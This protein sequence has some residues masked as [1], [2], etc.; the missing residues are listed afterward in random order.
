MA[1]GR[2]DSYQTCGGFGT[3]SQGCWVN[4]SCRGPA[5]HWFE[6]LLECYWGSYKCRR[7]QIQALMALR[8]CNPWAGH[9]KR[10]ASQSARG[11]AD[12]CRVWV[13]CRNR[14]AGRPS[15]SDSERNHERVSEPQSHC[16]PEDCCARPA[17]NS[18]SYGTKIPPLVIY[19][20]IFILSSIIF[21][22]SITSSQLKQMNNIIYNSQTIK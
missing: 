20:N 11:P 1:S 12:A 7:L 9:S 14:E 18:H 21:L 5:A 6:G 22:T 2:C 15:R 17:R 16:P 19:E 8:N 3:Q 13:N 10:R 4:H